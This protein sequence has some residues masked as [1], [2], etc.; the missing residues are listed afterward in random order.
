LRP[1][2]PDP[3]VNEDANSSLYSIDPW[4]G[5]VTH[6]AYN[7][8]LPHHG[9]TDAI[10]FYH[11]MMLISAS[12]PGTTGAAAPNPRRRQ[13]GNYQFLIATVACEFA[14]VIQLARGE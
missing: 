1:P 4:T 10:S 9:G 5:Q 3:A 7:K 6:Y 13:P 11:G 2:R 8:A 12:A 14:D